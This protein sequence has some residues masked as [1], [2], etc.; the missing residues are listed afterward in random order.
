MLHHQD[1]GAM[2]PIK[3]GIPQHVIETPVPAHKETGTSPDDR[4]VDCFF[5][6]SLVGR[7]VYNRKGSLVLETPMKDGLK[8]GPEFTWD[9]D[10]NLLLVEP[11]K[12]GKVHGMAKQFGRHGKVIGTYTMV[13]GTGFDVWRQEEE[14]GVIFVSE[15][16]SLQDGLPHGYEW[17]FASSKQDLWY[18]RHWQRGRLHGIER[19]WNRKG[20][21]RRG[22]PKFYVVDKTV[23]KQK[24]I[25]L[26]LID[27]TLPVFQEQENFSKRGLSPEVL[28]S[29]SF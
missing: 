22:Y 3:S 23:S 28:R 13:H 2:K 14:D 7:R 17:G 18:E 27:Q 16:H 11:Y 9:D 26:A 29:I 15:I 4:I 12:R 20:N 5:H 19:I 24:Y 1:S 25:K 10:G 6:G 21:L 8:H